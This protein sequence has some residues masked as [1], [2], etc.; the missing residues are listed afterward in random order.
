MNRPERDLYNFMAACGGNWRQAA[1]IPCGGCL[2]NPE[3][4]GCLLAFD[5]D[6]KPLLVG[7]RWLREVS[8]EAIDPTDCLIHI[9]KESLEQLLSAYIN[10]QVSN[11]G[12]CSLRQLMRQ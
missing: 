1:A 12:S 4:E 6:G 3:C 10:W 5:R 2:E 7:L 8:G 11:P 9:R